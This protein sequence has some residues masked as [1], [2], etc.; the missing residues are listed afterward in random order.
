MV[1][2]SILDCYYWF[3]NSWSLMSCYLTGSPQ[4]DL[5]IQNSEFGS[6][7]SYIGKAATTTRAHYPFLPVCNFCV[8]FQTIAW[9]PTVPVFRIFN[10]HTAVDACKFYTLGAVCCRELPLKVDWGRKIL[11]CMKNQT[12]ISIIIAPAL[13]GWCWTHWAI[14]PCRAWEAL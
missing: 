3:L 10:V 11:C 6:P 14:R 8:C 4:N 5:H 1:L 7:Y 9:V 2:L 13:L 12:H